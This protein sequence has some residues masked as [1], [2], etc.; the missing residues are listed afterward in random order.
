MKKWI[1]ILVVFSL[2]FLSGFAVYLF[3]PRSVHIDTQGLKY[4]LGTDDADQEKPVHV[5]VKGKIYRSIMGERQFIGTVDIE[6]EEIPVPAEQ[7]KL[8]IPFA[9]DHGAVLSYP[10]FEYRESG[11]VAYSEIFSYGILFINK[12]LNQVTIAVLEQ[13][14]VKRSGRWGRE[15]GHMISAPAGSRPEAIRISNPLMERYLSG[16]ELK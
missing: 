8:N 10:Y 2:V 14:R 12:E 4:R 6:G 16:F 11:A 7:R 9:R 3:Y 15:D 5:N 1:L 13:D